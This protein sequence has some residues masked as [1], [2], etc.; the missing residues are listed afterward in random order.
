VKP[1]DHSLNT[2]LDLDGDS[3]V[4]DGM[5]W[6]K[7]EAKRVPASSERPHGLDYSLTLHDERGARLLG[8][9]NA[10]R[11]QVGSGPGVRTRVEYDHKH[12]GQ[13]VRFY[14]YTDAVTLLTDF[15]ED[16][17]AILKE[18]EGTR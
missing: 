13:R 12:K 16:V 11:I 1:K 4:L 5:Y 10:H 14:N 3:Y 17:D 8:Y 6:V 15:W 7:F 2:L 18:R 9:D